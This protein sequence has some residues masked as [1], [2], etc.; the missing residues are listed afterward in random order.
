MPHKERSAKD[1]PLAPALFNTVYNFVSE[2]MAGPRGDEVEVHGFMAIIMSAAFYWN[3]GQIDPTDFQITDI[4]IGDRDGNGEIF[5]F[6]LANK[7]TWTPRDGFQI[8]SS[9]SEVFRRQ[10]AKLGN[11]RPGN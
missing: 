1:M 10:Y 4:V 5:R 9:S 8:S 6:G 2:F 3:E 11:G 7:L